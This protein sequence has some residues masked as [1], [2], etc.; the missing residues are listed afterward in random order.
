HVAPCSATHGNKRAAEMGDA[1]AIGCGDKPHERLQLWALLACGL[2]V[3]ACGTDRP[4]FEEADD[5]TD[6]VAASSTADGGDA[7]DG[8]A[9]NGSDVVNSNPDGGGVT[10]PDIGA[11][12]DR[13]GTDPTSM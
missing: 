3:S 12:T 11:D 9:G 10:G 1:M 13:D 4:D 8:A 6:G 2:V 7:D 5:P